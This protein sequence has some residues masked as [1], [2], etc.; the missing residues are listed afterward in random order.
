MFGVLACD[1]PDGLSLG[2][3]L[4]LLTRWCLLLPSWLQPLVLQWGHDCAVG[5]VGIGRRYGS[6]QW[7]V[8]GILVTY[9]GPKQ[10]LRTTHLM[11]GLPM[12]FGVLGD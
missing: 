10:G 11:L 4:F 7:Y 1:G 9:S 12:T 8:P 5:K 6:C 2:P 3:D